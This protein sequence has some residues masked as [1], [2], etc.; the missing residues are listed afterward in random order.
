MRNLFLSICLCFTIVCNCQSNSTGHNKKIGGPC[1][2]CEAIFEY[3]DKVLKDTDTLPDFSKTS[4]KLKLSG[5]VYQ[6]NGKTPAKN[7]ILYF[8]QTNR[9]GIY[10]KKGDEK[11]WGKRH[12]Y[13]RGWVKT[14]SVGHY[15]I[16]TFRPGA[17]PNRNTPEHIHITV[18]EPDKNEYYIEDVL[19]DDDVLLTL[20]KRKDLKQRG[21]S[22]IVNPV[23]KNGILTVSR[24][25]IL[26]HNIPNY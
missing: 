22:G 3:G 26:G 11:G 23:L 15:T 8:Y 16:Y 6:K 19:F 21:G 25:I 9:K 20:S 13:L 10:P 17:Y 7:V 4:P 1:Q 14:N 12:G 24:D 18:K 5:T 2:G